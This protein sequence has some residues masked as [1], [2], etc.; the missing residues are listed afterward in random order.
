MDE[1][2]LVVGK[3][4]GFLDYSYPLGNDVKPA[5]TKAHDLIWGAYMLPG[6]SDSLIT[7]YGKNPDSL[8]FISSSAKFQ[9]HSKKITSIVINPEDSS[10]RYI[11]TD[12]GE[13]LAYNSDNNSWSGWLI[14]KEAYESDEFKIYPLVIKDKFFLINAFFARNR[15][16]SIGIIK[17]ELLGVFI[18]ITL[19]LNSRPYTPKQLP[20]TRLGAD[21]NYQFLFIDG[22]EFYPA[23]SVGAITSN[24]IPKS[25]LIKRYGAGYLINLSKAL[26]ASGI[27]RIFNTAGKLIESN[28]VNKGTISISIPTFDRPSGIYFLSLVAENKVLTQK[29]IHIGL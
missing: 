4:N 5:I 15:E 24:E 6:P 7:F 11:A 14:P 20:D 19:S 21:N 17:P 27:L 9:R 8:A 22:L 3:K 23:S 12:Q 2:G 10:K 18:P 25:M 26:T 16:F 29:L 28:E 1:H 13:I